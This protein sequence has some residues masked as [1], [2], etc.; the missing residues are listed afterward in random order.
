M[1]KLLAV[2]FTLIM[3]AAAQASADNE[4]LITVPGGAPAIAVAGVYADTPD[5]VRKRSEAGKLILSLRRSMPERNS[6]KQGN[7][8]IALPLS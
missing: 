3:L 6:I 5:A 8:P 2:L 1:K 4:F 7:R